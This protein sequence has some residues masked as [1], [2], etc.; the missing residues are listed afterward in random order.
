VD[1]VLVLYYLAVGVALGLFFT[2][3][4]GRPLSFTPQNVASGLLAIT[5]PFLLQAFGASFE[6]GI[7]LFLVGSGLWYGW[8]R[9][10][11]NFTHS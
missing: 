3:L 10:R 4:S 7:V 6:L 1:L 8:R 9:L 2:R 5:A 11:P